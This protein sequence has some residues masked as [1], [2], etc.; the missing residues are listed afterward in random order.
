MRWV[1]LGLWVAIASL[2]LTSTTALYLRQGAREVTVDD[3]LARFREG[4]PEAGRSAGEDGDGGDEGGGGGSTTTT[5]AAEAAPDAPA[6][7][8]APAASATPAGATAERSRPA[9]AATGGA[10]PRGLTP[11]EEGVYVYA[12][13]GFESTNALGGARHD[14]PAET[15]ATL[16]RSACGGYVFRWEPLRERWD[17]S[18]LCPEGEGVSIRRFTPYHEF[19]QRG[20]QQDFHCPVNSHVFRPNATPGATWTWHCS[21]SNGAIDSV[22][23]FIGFEPVVVKGREVR[24][25]RLLYESKMTGSNRGTQR[26]ERWLDA[27]TGMNVRIKTDIDAETDSPFG[28][29]R[30]EEHYTITLT[31][32]TP[33]R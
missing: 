25:A 14:Y 23:T 8:G 27:A 4:T 13:Q 30:Y 20:Q 2:L 16:R 5:A 22:V 3:A 6:D 19:F 11:A 15:A 10:G 17:E 24:T 33:R 29:V 1:R 26:Q 12:T 31:S 9:Q 28:A 32:M 21:T 18:E 7:A